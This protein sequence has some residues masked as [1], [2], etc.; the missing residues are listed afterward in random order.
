MKLTV[1][2][3]DKSEIEDLLSYLKM[4][5]INSWQILD[6]PQL[7]V[8]KGDKTIDPKAHFGLW[9]NSPK[10]IEDIRVKAWN[11]S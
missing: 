3:S 4:H 11:R 8:E 6:Y 2:I 1:E 5:K 10:N 7:T 9:K